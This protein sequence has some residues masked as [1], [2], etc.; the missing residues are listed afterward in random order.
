ME[1]GRHRL[2]ITNGQKLREL[3]LVD[4][5]MAI[6]EICRVQTIVT[7]TV[8]Q[9]SQIRRWLKHRQAL[10]DAKRSNASVGFCR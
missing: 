5:G 6:R 1:E 2:V 4:Q 9:H 7:H 8:V 10:V 3:E